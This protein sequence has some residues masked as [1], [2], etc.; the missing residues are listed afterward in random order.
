MKHFKSLSA[1]TAASAIAL[2]MVATPVFA[3]PYQDTTPISTIEL[4]TITTKGE[5]V[6]LPTALKYVYDVWDGNPSHITFDENESA[7]DYELKEAPNG[8]AT[9]NEDTIT[10][11]TTSITEPGIYYFGVKE[12]GMGS[13]KIDGIINAGESE[14][15]AEKVTVAAVVVAKVDNNGTPIVD[16]DG[17]QQFYVRQIQAYNATGEKVNP[18]DDY[19]I[20]FTAEYQTYTLTVEKIVKGNMTTATDRNKDFTIA[21]TVTGQSTDEKF[22]VKEA[23]AITSY[24]AENGTLTHQVTLKSGHSAIVY[25]LSPN[26]KASVVETTESA[27]GYVVTY[28]LD[29]KTNT[30]TIEKMD[31]ENH[32]VVVT[33]T[34]ETDKPITGIVHTYGPYALMAA[35]GVA[36]AGFFFRRRREE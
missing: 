19:T 14:D 32:K 17:N 28:K 8:F 31:N 16:D 20:P 5:N 18:S 15:D 34:K 10:F 3:E 21:V 29:E 12:A 33:N 26:D 35:I 11:D 7:D 30:S 4:G 36:F 24:T 6:E 9:L 1:A 22:S 13:D 25:G 2:S 23:D 27:D